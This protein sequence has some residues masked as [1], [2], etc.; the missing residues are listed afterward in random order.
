[1]WNIVWCRK[2]QDAKVKAV[3]ADQVMEPEASHILS[4]G[5]SDEE[6]E[7]ED[8]EDEQAGELVHYAGMML[9]GRRVLLNAL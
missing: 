3:K 8:E 6:D 5:C 2:G 1:M 4:G 9:F 7:D